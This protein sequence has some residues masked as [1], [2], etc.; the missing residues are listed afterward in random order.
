MTGLPTAFALIAA[1]WFARAFPASVYTWDCRGPP[2]VMLEVACLLTLTDALQYGTHRTAHR[3]WY[4]SHAIHHHFV[5]PR[6]TDAFRTGFVDAVC[7]LIIPVLASVRIVAPSR[8]A[9]SL[10][11]V[12]YA[13]WL[14]FIHSDHP[15]CLRLTSSVWVTPAYHREHHATP[16]RNFG[17][18]LRVWDVVAGTD[19]GV[20]SPCA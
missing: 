14:Q 11:G 20:R 15:R 2:Y 1:A 18:L 3:L 13:M 6:A 16:N 17:H 4:G 8:I 12:L 10:F 19:A 7:Q 5:R 9:V